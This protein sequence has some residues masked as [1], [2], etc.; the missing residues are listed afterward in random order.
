MRVDVLG[1]ICRSWSELFLGSWG[2]AVAFLNGWLDLFFMMVMVVMFFFFVMVVMGFITVSSV[3]AMLVML[4]VFF[5]VLF[6]VFR[7][8]LLGVVHFIDRVLG[9]LAV[10]ESE[11]MGVDDYLLRGEIWPTDR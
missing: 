2:S 10:L 1:R 9:V 3:L 7:L 5:A 11:M 4:V 8:K 6:A